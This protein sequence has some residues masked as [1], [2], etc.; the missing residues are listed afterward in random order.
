MM[1]WYIKGIYML[2]GRYR[3]LYADRQ[4]KRKRQSG[5]NGVCPGQIP[6]RGIVYAS[7]SSSESRLQT[8]ITDV[9]LNP[10]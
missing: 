3:D 6:R 10:K 7:L 9:P 8:G 4:Q 1:H 5:L 2:L